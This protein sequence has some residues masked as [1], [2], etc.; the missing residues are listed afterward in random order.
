[1]GGHFNYSRPGTE[2]KK[3]A[4]SL[5]VNIYRYSIQIFFVSHHTKKKV[6]TEIHKKL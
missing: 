4:A 3:V 6:N 2:K 5:T 1:M